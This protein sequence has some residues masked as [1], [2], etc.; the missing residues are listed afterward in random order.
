MR[1]VSH[2]AL[3]EGDQISTGHHDMVL[4]GEGCREQ[5][6]SHSEFV[7]LIVTVG[8]ATATNPD[9]IVKHIAQPPSWD[10]R[11]FH[12]MLNVLKEY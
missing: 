4:P 10:P 12:T 9:E 3:D 7:E 1:L 8:A 11:E 2:A 6:L 5:A